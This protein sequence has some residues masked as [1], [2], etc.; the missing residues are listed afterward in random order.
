MFRSWEGFIMCNANRLTCKEGCLILRSQFNLYCEVYQF[1]LRLGL[2]STPIR[3]LAT[4]PQP[5]WIGRNMYES[6]VFKQKQQMC[7]TICSLF[8]LFLRIQVFLRIFPTGGK[9]REVKPGGGFVQKPQCCAAQ[10]QRLRSCVGQRGWGSQ[11]QESHL[12]EIGYF[13][14]DGVGMFGVFFWPETKPETGLRWWQSTISKSHGLAEVEPTSWCKKGGIWKSLF[15][16]DV[17]EMLFFGSV[18]GVANCKR[19]KCI[20]PEAFAWNQARDANV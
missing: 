18:S 5:C 10:E 4:N 12:L 2:Q 6:S 20:A 11:G 17:A 9:T 16:L 13:H 8:F 19:C 7:V 14:L 15:C 3:I 1:K